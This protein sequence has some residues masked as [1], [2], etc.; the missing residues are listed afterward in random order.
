MTTEEA[1]ENLYE[2]G[3]RDNKIEMF[4]ELVNI[5]NYVQNID[6]SFQDY[7]ILMKKYINDKR[8][9]LKGGK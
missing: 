6:G 2:L 8:I 1:L 5:H 7:F 9:E 3:K 4:N